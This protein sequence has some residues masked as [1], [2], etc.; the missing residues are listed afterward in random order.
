[1]AWKSNVCCLTGDRHNAARR[2]LIGG[3]RERKG[4]VQLK[5]G[6]R[7]DEGSHKVGND[8]LGSFFGSSLLDGLD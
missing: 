8:V 7:N 4:V 6:V 2:L 3:F 1:M 5:E